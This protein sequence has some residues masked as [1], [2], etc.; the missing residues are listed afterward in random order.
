VLVLSYGSIDDASTLHHPRLIPSSSRFPSHHRPDAHHIIRL[1]RPSR[2][3]TGRSSASIGV[4]GCLKLSYD[5]AVPTCTK[6]PS[7]SA[8]ALRG[9]SPPS[10]IAR[11]AASRS[12]SACF[13]FFSADE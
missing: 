3:Y 5:D 13:H 10:I 9:H 6:R 8:W 11:A 12:A 7:L 1:G 2:A 4:S